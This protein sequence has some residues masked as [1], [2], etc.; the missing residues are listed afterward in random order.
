MNVSDDNDGLV[1]M[2]HT[3]FAIVTCGYRPHRLT[4]EALFSGSRKQ[5]APLLKTV[6][7]MDQWYTA[8]M[9]SSGAINPPSLADM[10]P[11]AV[12]VCL[13][14]KG[15]GTMDLSHWDHIE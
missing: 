4:Q 3:V 12:A 2:E 14:G 8:S 1:M 13:E 6:V 7:G 9:L 10:A 11:K 15:S 5:S